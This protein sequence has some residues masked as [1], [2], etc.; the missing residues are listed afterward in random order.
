VA[1]PQLLDRLATLR[2]Q[3]CVACFDHHGDPIR[4]LYEYE[5]AS[6]QRQVVQAP[7]PSCADNVPELRCTPQW[8]APVDALH[9]ARCVPQDGTL[10]R[11]MCRCP[12]RPSRE[13]CFRHHGGRGC[14]TVLVA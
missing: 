8:L 9:E 4:L 14:S 6:H 13:C 3:V 5:V 7:R 10:Q 1:L 11:G 12:N 2:I